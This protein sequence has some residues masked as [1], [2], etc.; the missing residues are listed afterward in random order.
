MIKDCS[1]SNDC[2]FIKIIEKT[3]EF[4]SVNKVYQ[5]TK[6][7]LTTDRVSKN[8]GNNGHESDR[9]TSI[10]N[11]LKKLATPI[12]YNAKAKS[13]TPISTPNVSGYSIKSIS[14]YV[15]PS[16]NKLIS[17]I[18][19]VVNPVPLIIPSDPNIKIE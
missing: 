11:Y 15:S 18:S 12:Y 1:Y 3:N 8:H 9:L 16:S 4:A 14:N 2:T 6:V 10:K 19:K 7:T 5:V 17:Q 13:S